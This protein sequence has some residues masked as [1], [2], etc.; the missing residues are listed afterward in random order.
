LPDIFLYGT[1]RHLPLLEIVLGRLPAGAA[2]ARLA[3]HEVRWVAGQHY[4]MILPVPGT[5]AE[6][7]LLRGLSGEDMARLRFY[8]GGF[9]F[10]L[11]EVT[12]Q[13][14]QG[15]RPAQV[16]FPDDPAIAPGAPWRL[17]DWV[18]R[19]GALSCHA[20]RE[21]M[22]LRA[23]LT[24]EEVATRFAMIRARA[25]S[26]VL[27]EAMT[28]PEAG[29][30][31]LSRAEVRQQAHRRPYVAHFAMEE[32]DL[33]FRR[34]DGS[35]SPTVRRA[36]L[37]ATDASIVLP[38]DPGRDRVML[39][40]QFRAGPWLRA[41]PRPWC[42]EPVAGRVDPGEG[43]EDTAHREALEE[44]GLTFSA[45]HLASRSYPS[46]GCSSEFFHVYVGIADLPDSA[47]GHGGVAEEA[48]DIRLHL[49]SFDRM[50]ELA[51]AQALN[52]GPLM[53][54]AYWLSHHR[55]RLRA[56]A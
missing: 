41:D 54:A 36:C 10:D 2:P 47:A 39:L 45:L 40:E 46:P 7:V 48:E 11:R 44:A 30:P 4:P 23:S 8:E 49:M 17:E 35:M 51:E 29:T 38:Y 14:G 13:T 43:P 31:G 6:G 16:F 50:M 25:H 15:A 9:A 5:V 12:V 1:L 37:V 33:S 32:A 24:A 42:L 20:A 19:W 56:T 21:V 18:A 26:K 34:F 3:G 55:E 22:D 27:A 28:R 53:L 52:V